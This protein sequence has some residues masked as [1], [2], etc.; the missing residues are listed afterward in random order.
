M[1][2]AVWAKSE[3][4][5]SRLI[6]VR[7]LTLVIM[8]L[9][10]LAGGAKVSAQSSDKSNSDNNLSEAN[11]EENAEPVKDSR[12]VSR[13]RLGRGP[14]EPEFRSLDGVVIGHRLTCETD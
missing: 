13:Q 8:L 3:K 6:K 9:I 4:L 1:H 7:G 12:S 11:L 2:S 14:V 10:G 5:S